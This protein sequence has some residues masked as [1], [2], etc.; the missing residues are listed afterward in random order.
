VRIGDWVTHPS[1]PPAL[2]R[3]SRHEGRVVSFDSIIAAVEGYP[4]NED[5]L[6]WLPVAELHA[7]ET[8]QTRLLSYHNAERAKAGL[9]ALRHDSRLETAAQ[10]WANHMAASGVLAHV[11][12]ANRIRAAGYPWTS[13]AENIAEGQQTAELVFGSWMGSPPH[14][15]NIMGPYADVGFGRAVDSQGHVW[16]C[17]DFGTQ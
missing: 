17:S 6:Y 10:Q 13:F 3:G 1:L 8:A 9:P 15:A 16:W 2:A 14:R 7:T 12:V 5:W 4:G 11:D